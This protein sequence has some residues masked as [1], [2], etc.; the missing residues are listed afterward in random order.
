MRVPL[1][2]RESRV[3]RGAVG[4]KYVERTSKRAKYDDVSQKRLNGVKLPV[5]SINFIIPMLSPFYLLKV[6]TE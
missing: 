3:K 1:P 4:P 2:Y 6:S 5:W